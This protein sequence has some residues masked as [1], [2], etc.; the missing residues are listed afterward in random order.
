MEDIINKFS[1]NNLNKDHARIEGLILKW[2]NRHPSIKYKISAV[3][4]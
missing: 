1:R 2:Q 3:V 4:F